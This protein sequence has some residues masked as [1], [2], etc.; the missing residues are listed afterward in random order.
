M[1][2][3]TR[4]RIVV[5]GMMSRTPVPGVIWQTMHYLLGFER[6]GCEVFYVE[7]HGMTPTAFFDDSRDDGWESAAAFVDSIMR[8]F[9]LGGR[10]AYH[11]E[12]GGGRHFGMSPAELSSLYGSAALLLNLHGAT[13]PRPEHTAGG[14]LVMVETDPVELG[15]QLAAGDPVAIEYAQ[16][17]SAFFT[18]AENLGR[19]G[20]RLPDTPGFD[21]LPTRQPVVL[22]FWDKVEVGAR[23]VFTTIGNWRQL[24]R[25]VSLD[26]EVYHW[27]KHLEFLRFLDL[28]ER[29]GATFELA[30]ASCEASDRAL[31][32]RHGWH[33]RTPFLSAGSLEDY[34]RFISSSYAEFT[35]AKDQN[36]RLQ[37]GWFSDRSATYLAAGRPVITQD[38]GFGSVLPTGKGL[39]AFATVDDAAAA[40]EEI[41]SNYSL[42]QRAARDLSREWF[43]SDVVLGDMLSDLGISVRATPSSSRFRGLPAELDLEPV[44]R[45]PLSLLDTTSALVEA[46]VRSRMQEAR[47]RRP[48][49]TA[50]GA[51]EVT[52]VIVVRD[53]A[54]FTAMCLESLL[55]DSD[56]PSFEVVVVDNGSRDQT[57]AMLEAYQ[58]LD[59][60]IRVISNGTNLGFAGANNQGIAS[61]RGEVIVLLNNDTIVTPGW[62]PPLLAHLDTPGIGIVGPT[63]NRT[64]N[65]AQIDTTYR[66]VAQLTRFA[67][68][69]RENF[70]GR[71]T[72]M[73]MLAMFCVA[74]RRATFDE[75]GPLDEGF[76]LGMFEDDDYAMRAGAAGYRLVCAE[77]A[78]VHHF[79]QASLG[80]LLRTEEYE[81][82]FE[83]NRA[84]FE[85]KWNRSWQPHERRATDEYADLC[86]RVR[87]AVE[88]TVPPG[89]TVL[90]TAKG[91]DAL[92]A[93]ES[94][95]GMHYPGNRDGSFLGEY[96]PDSASAIEMLEQG[97]EAGAGYVMF[98]A[99]SAWWLEHYAGLRA[100][101]DATYG[102]PI[103]DSVDLRMWSLAE[104]RGATQGGDSELAALRRIVAEQGDMLARMRAELGTLHAALISNE[105]SA[106]RVPRDNEVPDPTGHEP[107]LAGPLRDTWRVL[108]HALEEI[109]ASKHTRYLL[110]RARLRAQIVDLTAPGSTIA[111]VSRGDDE[112]IAL[113]GR[114]AWHVP[115]LADGSWSAGLPG[116]GAEAVRYI[117]ILRAFGA[118]YLVLPATYGWWLD[119]YRELAEH[120]GARS[121][122]QPVDP[123]VGWIWDLRTDTATDGE[124][125]LEAVVAATRQRLAGEDPTVLDWHTGFDLGSRFPGLAVFSPPEPGVALPYLDGTVDIVAVGPCT[126]TEI[127]E[128][129][130]VAS[131]AVAQLPAD[132]NVTRCSVSW[133]SEPAHTGPTVSIVAAMQSSGAPSVDAIIRSLPAVFAGEILVPGYGVDSGRL[134]PHAPVRRVPPEATIVSWAQAA[135]A[136]AVSDIVV[137][138]D[139]SLVPI[140]GWLDALVANLRETAIVG[141]ITGVVLTPSADGLG[142]GDRVSPT[143]AMLAI[144]RDLLRAVGGLPPAAGIAEAC[145]MLAE[146]LQGAGHKVITDPDALAVRADMLEHQ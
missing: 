72:N 112:L 85:S 3:S 59:G 74:A 41:R 116:D 117:E 37:T 119:F 51:P 17:H 89:S 101:L 11:A 123:E 27:S 69:R 60:R 70:E 122:A 92:L 100:H 24:H 38:T 73:K 110:L 103:I 131:V 40:V 95:T 86:S 52:V 56:A 93:F 35:V 64:C 8:Q 139:P 98:P 65:E 71:Y 113:P 132:H 44:S 53:R 2:S 15:T 6:L 54:M 16:A 5:L 136:A 29:T 80:T 28:P 23:P 75:I 84:R 21:F 97:R 1:P 133:K 114:T 142:M 96:P 25:S 63:T 130:R 7:D 22:D 111:V 91:D 140:R 14:R 105:P 146:S 81:Q 36:I 118:D 46:R 49:R 39:L 34:R 104:R 145:A 50:A 48:T 87:R 4:P 68:E 121:I 67:E 32:A 66:T 124:L 20:C 109:D 106:E 134:D 61:A 137:F 108:D 79:G 57:P 30:L 55:A 107:T 43:S 141:A 42:H 77:D 94:R 31:L 115:R 33:T 12:H 88:E 26:D 138:I 78:Y 90:V 19:P 129:A 126:A 120:L 76:E 143:S 13:R 144:R 82:L 125:S 62:L 45:W 99:P 127:D 128:A 135:T 102:R 10:W 58:R 83:R 18:F 47:G 9:G